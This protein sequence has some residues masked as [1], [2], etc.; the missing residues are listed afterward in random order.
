MVCFCFM[1]QSQKEKNEAIAKE[2]QEW[3]LRSEEG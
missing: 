1:Y 3:N 2:N